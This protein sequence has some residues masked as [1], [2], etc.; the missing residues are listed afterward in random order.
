MGEV[1]R[2]DLVLVELGDRELAVGQARMREV[3]DRGVD[4]GCQQ[5]DGRDRGLV[6]VGAHARTI[7]T[8]RSGRRMSVAAAR[9]RLDGRARS[10]PE[11]WSSSARPW[12]GR[13]STRVSLTPLGTGDVPGR[14]GPGETLVAGGWVLLLD[15]LPLEPDRYRDRGFE[16][17]AGHDLTAAGRVGPADRMEQVGLLGQVPARRRGGRTRRGRGTRRRRR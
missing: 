3:R 10:C 16:R 14:R 4:D 12:S 7:P 17:E 2:H 11:G 15:E 5:V 1:V 9:L 8:G 6:L 13:P